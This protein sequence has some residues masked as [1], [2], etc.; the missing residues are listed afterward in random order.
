MKNFC[1][2]MFHEE[3]YSRI[4]TEGILKCFSQEIGD[5]TLSD[6][7]FMTLRLQVILSVKTFIKASELELARIRQVF[8]LRLNVLCETKPNETVAK[9]NQTKPL[10]NQTKPN[11]ISNAVLH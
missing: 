3:T 2:K 4:L 7:A 1:I 11:E 10:R 8:Y 9:R 6:Q 5:K